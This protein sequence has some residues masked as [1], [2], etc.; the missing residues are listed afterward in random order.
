MRQPLY[1][2]SATEKREEHWSSPSEEID[3]ETSPCFD[4]CG[5]SNIFS[6]SPRRIVTIVNSTEKKTLEIQ[7]SSKMLP[8]ATNLIPIPWGSP[9]WVVCRPTV[10]DWDTIQAFY[11][12]F[13]WDCKDYDA[14]L[15]INS[16]WGNFNLSAISR[17]VSPCW[18]KKETIIITKKVKCHCKG[19][20]KRFR[21]TDSQVWQGLWMSLGSNFN[22]I[23][24]FFNNL[25][26]T[27]S[28]AIYLRQHKANI[29]RWCW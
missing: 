9:G 20:S 1:K 21:V 28:G 16:I 7:S 5:E 14:F 18:E 26:L 6:V 22:R 4:W 15:S 23:T 10:Q 24:W 11:Y 19:S 25:L 2:S 27:T 8:M 17:E 12:F 13:I 29:R 3:F